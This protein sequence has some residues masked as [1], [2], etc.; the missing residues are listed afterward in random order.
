[1]EPFYWCGKLPCLGEKPSR[2]LVLTFKLGFI[3][4]MAVCVGA[5]KT[6]LLWAFAADCF[7]EL[8][9]EL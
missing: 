1:M 7:I 6:W 4:S 3:F 2:A 8:F 9:I 5:M